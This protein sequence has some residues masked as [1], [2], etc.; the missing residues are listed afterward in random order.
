MKKMT[1]LLTTLAVLGLATAA[2]AAEG[3]TGGMGGQAF[4]YAAAIAIAVAA[5]CGAF[6][7]SMA[8]KSALD[9]IGRNPSAAG[10]ITTPMIIG[11]AMIESL[12]I[13]AL[14]IA[15]MLVLKI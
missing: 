14:V 4:A 5:S 10:K 13:Y 1:Q 3:A 8:I 7:Q 12:V 2:M 9:S 15:L 11:L 6:G